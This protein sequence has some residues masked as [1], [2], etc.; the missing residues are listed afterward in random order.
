[1]ETL[2]N[3]PSLQTPAATEDVGAIPTQVEDSAAIQAEAAAVAE[4]PPV[5]PCQNP[6]RDDLVKRQKTLA[7]EPKKDGDG[8][9]H[10][11]STTFS[12]ET[13][14]KALAEMIII[15]ELPFRYVEGYGFKKYVTTLQP[16][17][18][19]KDIPSCQTMA[20]DVIGIY[21]SE[22]D[23]L[24]KSLKGCRVCLTTDTWTSVQILNYMCL[25]CHFIDDAWKLHKRI[26]NFCQV[27]DH[28]GETIGRKIEMSLREWGIDGI[29]TLTVDNAS[30]NLTTIK[31]LQRVTKDWNGTV[32]GNEYMHMRCCAHILNLIVGEG[33]KEIDVFVAMVREAVRYV[34]SS[35]NRSQTF[36]SFMERLGMESKSLLSLDVPTKWNLTY[37]MLETAEKFEKVF[38]RM[39]FEDDGYSSYFRTKEDSGGLGSPCMADFQNCRS[40][41]TFLRLFY[42]ATTKFSG[43]LYVTSNAFYDEIFVIQESISNLVKSQNTLLKNTATNMQTKFEKYWGEGEKINPLLYVAVVLDPRKKL[44]FLKF[45]FS[46]IYGNLVAEVMVDKVKD[47]LY[48][49]Y[50]FYSSIHSP[51]VQEQSESE[52]SELESDGNDPYVMVHSRYE[53]FLEVEQSAGCSNELEKYLAENCDGRKDV[54]FEILEWWRDN[55]S[56][57]Q[58]LSKVAK[59]M[60]AVPISTVA[61]ESAFSTSGRIVDPFRSSLSPLMVQ[62][63]VCSQNWLQATKAA[64][65]EYFGSFFGH[66]AFLTCN[67]TQLSMLIEKKS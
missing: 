11:V 29:F 35:P 62:N 21:N 67:D 12:V 37:I 13:S 55:C 17:L 31:F 44:R 24:R 65:W 50:N 47:L 38:L 49:L 51:N 1:M 33:L 58:V 16:K 34:K 3:E 9:F 27:E 64:F 42:N 53:R 48:K 43:S 36:R 54:N 23:K 20:R 59:D 45:S 61:S 7:F 66:V 26:L 18:Q 15:D 19:L 5:P 60:L 39:D 46:E 52:R 40:F 6:N 2:A 22:R 57:Y 10:L 56:R 41:V 30:S 4:L 14:R 25:K 8:E 32:L 28:K 63:L